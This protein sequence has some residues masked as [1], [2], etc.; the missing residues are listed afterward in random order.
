MLKIPEH[1]TLQ[2]EAANTEKDA[3]P[4]ERWF[5]HSCCSCSL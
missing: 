5:G 1:N 3:F 2:K 4:E